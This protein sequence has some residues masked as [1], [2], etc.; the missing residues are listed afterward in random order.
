M[1][2]LDNLLDRLHI[3]KGSRIVDVGFG[4][5]EELLVLSGVVGETGTVFGIERTRKLVEKIRAEL[6]GTKNIRVMVG[7]A[8]R[9]PVPESSA[10][11]V[12]FKGVLHEVVDVHV[13]LLEARRI[14][15]N[16]GRIIILDFSPFPY[17]WLN[18]SNLKWRVR[19][20]WRILGS[21]PDLHPGFSREQIISFFEK[22]SLTEERYEDNF[23]KGGFYGRPVPMFLAISSVNK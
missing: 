2:A 18:R 23:A 8:S 22:A 13:A 17:K 12:L 10:N 3:A 11:S 6:A 1:N 14:C 5:S 20:P 9:M 7:D 19:H 21:P 15:N 16:D 4:R